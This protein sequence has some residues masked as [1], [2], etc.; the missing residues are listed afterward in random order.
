[1]IKPIIYHRI[2]DKNRI[3]AE[4]RSNK[5]VEERLAAW[6]AITD[7]FNSDPSV[8]KKVS[9]RLSKHKIN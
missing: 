4:M 9:E 7:F 2:E 1:M 5:S 8:R 3:E 6:K